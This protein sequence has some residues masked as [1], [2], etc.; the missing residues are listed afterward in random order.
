MAKMTTTI[1][2]NSYR[3]ADSNNN[4]NGNSTGSIDHYDKTVTTATK[5]ATGTTETTYGKNKLQYLYC[6]VVL[7]MYRGGALRPEPP[8]KHTSCLAKKVIGGAV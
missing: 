1:T 8:L 5:V 3:N 7:H 2:N 4:N 6:G